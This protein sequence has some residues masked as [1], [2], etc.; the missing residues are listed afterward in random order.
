MLNI[1]FDNL[2]SRR[3]KCIC[4]R[5]DYKVLIFNFDIHLLYFIVTQ[6]YSY[7]NIL[8]RKKLIVCV[9]CLSL[10][11][12]SKDPKYPVERKKLRKKRF[13]SLTQAAMFLVHA[14]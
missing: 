4:A 12:Q 7:I 6:S 13:I 9:L 3:I 8:D 10:K 1:V 5:L 2:N 11:L 14:G